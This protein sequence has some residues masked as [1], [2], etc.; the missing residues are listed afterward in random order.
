[1]MFNRSNLQLAVSEEGE[2]LRV[3]ISGEGSSS[4]L[5]YN[6]HSLPL[7]EEDAPYQHTNFAYGQS[8]YLE[9]S[10]DSFAINYYNRAPI[11]DFPG[12]YTDTNTS[13]TRSVLTNPIRYYTVA[14]HQRLRNPWDAPF[15]FEDSPHVFYVKTTE[16]PVL[17]YDY[18]N[19]GVMG[20]P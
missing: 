10:S 11:L 6:T 12:V 16:K 2:A 8:R 7:R 13:L 5:L 4:F 15:F 19:Y 9:T 1:T 18:F 3:A 17:I 20:N 14:P